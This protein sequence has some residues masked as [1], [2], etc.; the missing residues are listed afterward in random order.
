MAKDN[1]NDDGNNDDDNI[2]LSPLPIV[3]DFDKIC[4]EYGD[5]DAIFQKNSNNDNN[6]DSDSDSDIVAVTAISYFELQEHSKA[7]AQ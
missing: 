5:R 7:L 3:K 4:F 6:S 1:E 2:Y